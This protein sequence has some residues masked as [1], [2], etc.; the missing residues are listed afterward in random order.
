MFEPPPEPEPNEEEYKESE[1]LPKQIRQVCE[2]N[3]DAEEDTEGD[4]FHKFDKILQSSNTDRPIRYGSEFGRLGSKPRT[5]SP[6]DKFKAKTDRGITEWSKSYNKFKTMFGEL[7]D[8]INK[9]PRMNRDYEQMPMK[10]KNLGVGAP[11]GS[12]MQKIYL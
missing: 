7:E 10:L 8:Y 2:E 3:E 11:T 1:D 12:S 6:E 9:S 5:I 4:V